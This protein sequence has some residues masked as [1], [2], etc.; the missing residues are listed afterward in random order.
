MNKLTKEK[1]MEIYSEGNNFTD[2]PIFID[3]Y[4]D[5]WGPCKMFEQVLNEASSYYQNKVNMYKVNIEEEPQ[6]ASMF[7]VRSVPM[8]T[9]ISK[10]GDTQS[11]VG[12]MNK[13]TFTY[14]MAGLIT[15]K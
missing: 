7:G 15:K 2:K 13:E 6:I 11:T 8:V 10:S 14:Y 1:L 3:F 9:T 5:W 4:A 12:A